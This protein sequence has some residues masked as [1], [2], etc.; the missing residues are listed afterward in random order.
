VCDGAQKAQV[1]PPEGLG[2][3]GLQQHHAHSLA[4]DFQRY[5]RDRVDAQATRKAWS[6]G[7][8][9]FGVACQVRPPRAE[10]LVDAAA[11][12]EGQAAQTEAS[13]TPTDRGVRGTDRHQTVQ[14][15]SRHEQVGV[16]DVQHLHQ[17]LRGLIHGVGEAARAD[18][19]QAFEGAEITPLILPQSHL[20]GPG[21]ERRARGQL[22]LAQDALEM[23]G[24]RARAQAQRQ[25]DLR[26]CLATP[27]QRR[28]LPV[29]CGELSPG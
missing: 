8:I 15:G 14:V 25:P 20:D 6:H 13:L 10:D 28:D 7:R 5:G 24:D 4:G 19:Q 2:P 9:A 11:L 3:G 1:A 29:A 18:V 23:V 22:Q 27:D 26:V 17:H 16:V 12:L 21:G